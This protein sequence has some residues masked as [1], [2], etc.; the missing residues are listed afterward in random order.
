MSDFGYILAY[1][2]TVLA[3]GSL[4]ANNTINWS[5]ERT[6]YLGGTY[7]DTDQADKFLVRLYFKRVSEPDTDFHTQLDLP[8]GV[9]RVRIPLIMAP[10]MGIGGE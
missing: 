5:K 3:N 6:G 2:M 10:V 4:Q 8:K 9:R 1:E 7:E